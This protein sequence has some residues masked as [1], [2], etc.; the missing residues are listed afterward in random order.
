MKGGLEIIMPEQLD[1][2]LITE[3]AY[4]IYIALFKTDFTKWY[5]GRRKGERK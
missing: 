4:L 5:V 3:Q 2:M 1:I